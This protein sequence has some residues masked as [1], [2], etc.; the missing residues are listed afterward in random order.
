M[1]I[2]ADR[3]GHS[4]HLVDPAYYLAVPGPG[5]VPIPRQRPATAGARP[6]A[7]TVALVVAD[8]VGRRRRGPHKS[9]G[10]GG[11]GEAKLRKSPER[12]QVPQGGQELVYDNAA[13]VSVADSDFA[14]RQSRVVRQAPAGDAAGRGIGGD[15]AVAQALYQP[16]IAGRQGLFQ[17]EAVPSAPVLQRRPSTAAADEDRG[18]RSRSKSKSAINSDPVSA[19][20]A[21][22]EVPAG[23]AVVTEYRIF[24]ERSDRRRQGANA[25]ARSVAGK[26][27]IEDENA[28]RKA[29]LRE[30]WESNAGEGGPGCLPLPSMHGQRPHTANQ[31][32][33]S[34]AV[35]ADH[36]EG[37]SLQV[38]E[39]P[40]ARKERD[41]EKYV[42][43]M[44]ACRAIADKHRRPAHRRLKSDITNPGFV[45]PPPARPSATEAQVVVPVQAVPPPACRPDS[46]RGQRPEAHGRDRAAQLQLRTGAGSDEEQGAWSDE[47]GSPAASPL[48]SPPRAVRGLASR[49]QYRRDRGGVGQAAGDIKLRGAGHH[50]DG[51]MLPA[52]CRQH[53]DSAFR[54]LAGK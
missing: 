29:Q 43:I 44:D 54:I 40:Q 20:R 28:A 17:P 25:V 49:E 8:D 47:D 26:G 16:V 51:E 1:D 39:K 2:N 11:E 19:A 33:S 24:D 13:R 15:A 48:P 18:G 36:F 10:A 22:S 9:G 30:M 27:P 6:A 42:D 21:P 53:K 34:H 5:Q 38:A 3:K 41:L 31:R 4:R 52:Q 46:S 23:E 14:A 32:L 12:K 50:A 7:G 45:L 37:A 35:G